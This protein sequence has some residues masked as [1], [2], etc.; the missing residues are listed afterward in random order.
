M[1][2]AI[3]LVAAVL[4]AVLSPVLQ[5]VARRR[6]WTVAP[7]M[8]LAIAAIVSHLF[9][10]L[11][12]VLTLAQ[13]RYWDAASIFGFC[14]MGYVFA[15]GAVYKSVSL[16][17]L[18]ALVDRPGRAAP[19]SDVIDHWVPELFRGRTRILIEGQLVAQSGSTFVAAESGRIMARRI[20]FLR[21]AF[22]IGDTG[23]YDFAD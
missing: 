3:G 11:L 7:V 15:F 10:V 23:L 5:I 1:S 13:F 17:I 22:G 9:G 8:L 6:A 12:G 18:L 2:F 20:G 14:V 16:T 4:F 19:L 21:R